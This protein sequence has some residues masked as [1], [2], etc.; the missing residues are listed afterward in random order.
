MSAASG[1]E[2]S[3]THLSSTGQCCL[4]STCSLRSVLGSVWVSRALGQ[5]TLPQEQFTE[6]VQMQDPLDRLLSG[7]EKNG[8][9]G[10]VVPS[11]GPAA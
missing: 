6:K 3:Q 10:A 7:L 11:E 4:Y 2:S 1:Q 9:D 8:G 5:P